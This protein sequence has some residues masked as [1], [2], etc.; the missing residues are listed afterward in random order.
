[1]ESKKKPL[2][3]RPLQEYS[4][5]NKD[6][7]MTSV[8]ELKGLEPEKLQDEKFLLTVHGFDPESFEIA[9]AKNSVYE[10]QL[11]GGIVETCFSSKIT[12][13]KR[14]CIV[15]PETIT[16]HLEEFDR[17]YI[18]TKKLNPRKVNGKYLL[19]FPLCDAHIGKY[20]MEFE[21]GKPCNFG[22]IEKR[23]L[24]GVEDLISDI[25]HL[26]IGKVL[27]V[28]GNDYFHFDYDRKTVHGTMQDTDMK[29]KQ[30]YLKGIEVLIKVID[31]LS[32]VADV[33]VLWVPGNHDFTIGFYALRELMSW[34]RKDENVNI[35]E[36][37]TSR[38]YYKFGKVLLGFTHGSEESK[39]IETL[40]QEEA[41]KDWGLTDWHEWHLG[42]LHSESVK[43]THGLF[44]RRVSSLTPPDEWHKISGYNSKE[45]AQAFIWDRQKGL[46]FIDNILI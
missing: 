34:Y 23:I 16:K 32:E 31:R 1:M 4:Q 45:K 27:F 25:S 44:I 42:H 37:Y 5:F 22:V 20:A 12:V 29:I 21:V 10:I 36:D 14:D 8:K 18:T 13:K 30:M 3:T 39:R 33:D 41:C 38:K 24:Q 35:I 6:G 19:E 17:K 9:Y 43:E 26:P 40:M 11:K 15:S 7:T 46:K 28:F 2:K